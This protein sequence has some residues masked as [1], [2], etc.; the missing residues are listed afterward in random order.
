MNLHGAFR[1][2][3]IAADQLVGL[4]LHQELQHVSLPRGE[5][6]GAMLDVHAVAA[7]H[8]RRIGRQINAAVEHV[9]YRVEQRFGADAFRNEPLCAGTERR[10]HGGRVVRRRK[11]RYRHARI[12]ELEIGEEVQP[13]RTGQRKVEQHQRDLGLVVEHL[14]RLRRV[15]SRQDGQRRVELRQKL[16]EGVDDQRVIVDHE[17]V[18]SLLPGGGRRRRAPSRQRGRTVAPKKCA[19]HL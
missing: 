12:V 16:H 2:R 13:P 7:R 6:Q 14:R 19:E 8:A 3:E 1:Q 5:A 15:S 9:A 11:H 18:H 10:E 4:P 17:N